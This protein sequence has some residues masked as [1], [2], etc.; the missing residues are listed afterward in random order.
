MKHQYVLLLFIGIISCSKNKSDDNQLTINETSDIPTTISETIKN[1]D[2]ISYVGF[3]KKFEDN[4]T[5]YTDL[6]FAGDDNYN[7]Y[8]EI[9]KM[10]DSIVFEDDENYRKLINL[11]TA[12]KYFNLTGIQKINRMII[13]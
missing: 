3:I 8:I 11:E 2:T 9:S 1:E 6:Y 12:R 13:N 4:N 5:F 7:L 10:P